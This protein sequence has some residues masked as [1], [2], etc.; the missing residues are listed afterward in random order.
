MVIKL[1]IL[2]N[3]L[4]QFFKNIV[5]DK[6]SILQEILEEKVFFKKCPYRVIITRNENVWKAY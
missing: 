3:L 1:E 6:T 4:I 2:K 5:Y